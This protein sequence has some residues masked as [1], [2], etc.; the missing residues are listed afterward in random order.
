[1]TEQMT[2]HVVTILKEFRDQDDSQDGRQPRK[3]ESRPRNAR[4]DGH[5]LGED[6]RK[7]KGDHRRLQCPAKRR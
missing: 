7:S 2:E 3:N 1:M 4:K 6:R 5:R